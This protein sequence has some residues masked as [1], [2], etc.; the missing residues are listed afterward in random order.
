MGYFPA[1]FMTGAALYAGT[2]VY[3]QQ[4]RS[5]ATKPLHGKA[6]LSK[7]PSILTQLKKNTQQITQQVVDTLAGRERQQHAAAMDSAADAAPV[8]AEEQQANLYAGVAFASL[9]ASIAGH[10]LYPPLALLSIP[11]LI[12]TAYP[13]VKTG[14]DDLRAKRKVTATTLDLISIPTV[15]LMGNF[16]AASLAVSLLSLSQAV[17]KRTE[18]RSMQ[19]MIDVL[20]EQPATVWVLVDDAEVEI[21]FADLKAGDILVMTAGQMV[22]AD[23]VIVSGAASIDQRMLT[24][25]SQPAEKSAGDEVFAAS[26]L[27]A[28]RL[29]VEVKRAGK[30]TIAA[31]IADILVKTADHKQTFALRSQVLSDRW[32]LP[33][34]AVAGAALPFAGVGGSIAVLL[35]SLGYNLRI[36]G[37]L[38]MLNFLRLAARGGILVKEARALDVLP[39]IDTVVFDKTGTLTL[40]QP[41]VWQIHTYADWAADEIL[42]YAAAAESR[43]SHPIARAIIAAAHARALIIPP[44]ADARYEVG[45][46]LKVTLDGKTISI[47]SERFMGMEGVPLPSTVGNLHNSAHAQGHSLVFVSIDGIVAGAIELVPAVRPEARQTIAALAARGLTLY[48]ISGD[49]EQ[50]TRHL[51]E[52]LGIEHYFANVLPEHKAALLQQLQQDGRCVCFVG[53]GINDAIALKQAD[54][55]VSLRGASTIATDTAQIILMDASLDQF[56]ELFNLADAYNGNMRANYLISMVPGMA[57]IGGVFMLHFGVISSIMLYNLGLVIGVANAMSPLLRLRQESVSP[58]SGTENRPR[59]DRAELSMTDEGIKERP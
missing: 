20:G 7:S 12:Y 15:T 26:L 45:Y 44:I 31:K 19:S 11:G 28:G 39:T 14:Y 56:A 5:A 27:L 4:L 36:I 34:L 29:L 16:M 8:S 32:S 9:G 42:C 46:G 51:A 54:L 25:E 38:S 1:L 6:H 23:G 3:Q 43:Q 41:E 22:P 47:G 37:P 2:F 35:S 58:A 21:P 59:E 49:Q 13:F 33:T 50:P 10:V 30:A 52:M 48:I 53:D 55:S 18:E 57:V 40:E 17:L 24:G